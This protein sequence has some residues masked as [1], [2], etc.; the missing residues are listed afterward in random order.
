[1]GNRTI[2]RIL[3]VLKDGKR[4][5]LSE[6]TEK[7][8]M[9]P[10]KL[11]FILAFLREFQFIDVDNCGKIKLNSSMRQFLKEIEKNDAEPSYEEITA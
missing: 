9:R 4:R 10:Q 6:I 7:I 11:S 5:T 8:S 3:E 2:D 1:M